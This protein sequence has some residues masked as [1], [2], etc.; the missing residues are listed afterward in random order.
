M[1]STDAESNNKLAERLNEIL[2]QR[3]ISKVELANIAGVSPQS[4]NG[5]FKKGTISKSSAMKLA[6]AFDVPV[7]WL[8]GED[9]NASKSDE[10]TDE[11][12][13][14]LAVFRKLHGVERQNMLETWEARLEELREFYSK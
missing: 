2:H 11:E 3:R 9:E 10:L 7:T 13:R 14:L 8:F 6:A 1:K 5:W 4:V 12:Q